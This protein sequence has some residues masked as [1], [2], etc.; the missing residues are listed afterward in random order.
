MDLIFVYGTLKQGS[1]N[2]SIL[3][4]SKFV[5]RAVTEKNL[6]IKSMGIP[7][8]MMPSTDTMENTAKPI[9]GE[10]YKVSKKTMN[11]V[12]ILEGHPDLYK[13]IIID[14]KIENEIHK[15]YIYLFQQN[16]FFEEPDFEQE[17]NDYSIEITE[18]GYRW[19]D[20]KCPHCGGEIDILKDNVGVC[21]YCK[22]LVEF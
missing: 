21:Y 17:P 19:I 3:T 22:K 1:H 10:V 2:N 4:N 8:V 13:R 14:V 6:N 20:I 18:E 16:N 15:A 7:I 11:N 12:D 5:G 9:I